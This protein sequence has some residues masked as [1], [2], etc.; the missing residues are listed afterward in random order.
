MVNFHA[1]I[2]LIVLINEAAFADKLCWLIKSSNHWQ[3]QCRLRVVLGLFKYLL[4]QSP[5]SRKIISQR[6]TSGKTWLRQ[7]M[8]KDG[9]AHFSDVSLHVYNCLNFT[10]LFGLFQGCL[11]FVYLITDTASPFPSLSFLLSHAPQYFKWV[12]ILQGLYSFSYLWKKKI[13]FSSK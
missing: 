4:F 6:T 13:L 11:T 8:F 2:T 1:E 5:F 3:K 9:T 12:N 10:P 7:S